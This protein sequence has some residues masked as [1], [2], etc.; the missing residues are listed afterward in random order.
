MVDVRGSVKPPNCIRPDT[1]ERCAPELIA[2]P[3]ADA[4]ATGTVA[5]LLNLFAEPVGPNKI[6]DQS[7]IATRTDTNTVRRNVSDGLE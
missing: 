6:A 5:V 7:K 2:N 1:R 4:I 3:L